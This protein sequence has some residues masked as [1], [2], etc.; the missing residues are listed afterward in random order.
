[1]AQKFAAALETFS[2]QRFPGPA[3]FFFDVL[4]LSKTITTNRESGNQQQSG[5][6]LQVVVVV[7]WYYTKP[8]L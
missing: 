5:R 7:L 8:A 1:M 6:Q 2:S 3:A 4:R